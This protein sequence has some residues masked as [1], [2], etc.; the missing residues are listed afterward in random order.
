MMQTLFFSD[1]FE[2]LI[3][4]FQEAWYLRSLVVA[5]FCR[6]LRI[7]HTFS[8]LHIKSH[9]TAREAFADLFPSTGR[10]LHDG[11]I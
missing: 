3:L 10:V 4:F 6:Q 1:S 5:I 9:D 7:P 11:L 8:N 2:S